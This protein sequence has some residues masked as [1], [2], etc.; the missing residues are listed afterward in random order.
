[1]NLSIVG[2]AAPLL[3]SF[4]SVADG[5]AATRMPDR[6]L[7]HNSLLASPARL[8]VRDVPLV[9]A[10]SALQERSGVPLAY[11]PT[12]LPADRHVSC[13]CLDATV[14]QAL[15]RLLNGTPFR[16]AEFAGQVLIER[17]RDEAR[18]AAEALPLVPGVEPVSLPLT[19]TVVN[20]KSGQPVEDARLEVVGEGNWT[21]SGAL[22]EFALHGLSPVPVMLK[23]SKPGY[24][25]VA[26][27]AFPGEELRIRIKPSLFSRPQTARIEGRVT[28]ADD[29]R[30]LALVRVLLEGTS[31]G[32]L[33]DADGRYRIEN[34]PPGT[35]T[36]AAR[37]LGFAAARR[38]NVHVA[39]DA[40]VAADF[41]L[42]SAAV[43]LDEQVVLGVTDATAGRNLPFSV[44]RLDAQDVASVPTTN[45]AV[46]ALQGKIAGV[47][48]VRGTGQ[49]GV[50]VNIQLRTPTSIRRS[51]SPMFV[52]DGVILGSN[53][54]GTT[55]DLES[56]DIES[57]EVV[58]GAAAASLYGSRAASGVVAI[59][60]SRGRNAPQGR[61]QV[62]TR[63]EFGQ[64]RVPTG[65]P[66][67][68]HH[69]Y[70]VNAQGQF[71]DAAGNPVTSFSQRVVEPDGMM[72]NA[73]G[74]PLYD[75]VGAF[76]QPGRFLTN[77]ISLSHNTTASNFMVSFN[78]YREAG[79]LENNDG[80][81][82]RN[83]RV[84]LDHHVG[85]IFSIG[86][87]AFH[88]RATRDDLTGSPFFDLLLYPP[89]VDL[90]VRDADGNYIPEP[91]STANLENPIW[92]Q[93]SR[94]NT[95][96][97]MRTLAN[98]T[99]RVAPFSWL[100]F[101]GVLSY[102]RSD[103]VDDDYVPRGTP[104]S[105]TSDNPSLGQIDKETE[106][107]DVLN[108][109]ASMTLTGHVDE[110][111]AR[112]TL[113]ALIERDEFRDVTIG[114][115]D[116]R[117]ANVPDLSVAATR[118]LNSTIEDIR[119]NGY[120]AQT[121]L[122]YRD[123]YIADLLVRRDGSSLFGPN[124][125]WQTYYRAGFAYR[126]AQERWWPIRWMD[127]FKLRY[128][129]GT[130]GGRPEFGD[131]YE[132]WQ[133]G[134]TGI[135]KGTL[136]NKDLKPEKT[137]EQEFGLDVVALGRY[138]LQLSYVRQLTRDQLIDVP[139]PAVTGYQTQW[140][141]AGTEGGRSWEATFEAEV[142]TGPAVRWSTTVVADRHRSWIAEW[143][144]ACFRDGAR[145]F[146]EGS[147][148]G[149]MWGEHFLR[150]PAELP[151]ANQGSRDQFQLN[152]D[153]WL[154]PVG[155]GASYRDGLWGTTV[156]IDGID[157]RWGIPIKALDGSGAPHIARMGRSDGDLNFG[158][159]NHVRWKAW[160]LDAHVQGQIGGNIY[161]ATRQ[162]MYQHLRHGDVDQAGKPDALKKPIDYY[163]AI[164][165][166]NNRVNAFVEDGSFVRLRELA[167]R[168]RVEGDAL[169]RI[170]VGRLGVTQLSVGLIG[171]N[172]LTMT[173]YR[174]FDPDVGEVLDRFDEFD[175]PLT[176]TVTAVLELVF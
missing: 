81:V 169:R 50:G 28:A 4:V 5:Q 133:V 19:G 22:G 63:T 77:S 135:S 104:L 155:P 168:Y 95:E 20:A 75:N 136:G 23:V 149:E 42:R 39:A 150:S 45:S 173:G 175:Y 142:L 31:F 139:L 110:L 11:S 123:R 119:S 3:L 98:I 79:A 170:G 38:G 111:T 109:S 144:R 131:Q 48:V 134:T 88:S 158:W 73:Y 157:Y 156:N 16:Y 47:Q 125:R 112:V 87:S 130:A 167:L 8:H 152:D 101:N 140:Q 137:T 59:R 67:T 161:N 36:I 103:V 2:V 91:D 164:Y 83:F 18:A 160:S 143:G 76:F 71:V 159:L 15:D 51:N 56:L 1:M 122:E 62:T 93:A 60:T 90:G 126:M 154:V 94:D 113:Q 33:T 46:A 78:D 100:T 153:G 108:A 166:S 72:D 138:A 105:V 35:Y 85:A 68:S 115:S 40:I 120:Y 171:R 116:L 84:N 97:R 102:D 127:E 30:P 107:S 43:T 17:S 89:D 74:V 61:T 128:S 132:T 21:V 53:I 82:R 151:A 69:H 117:V 25:G 57:I 37:L 26:T 121:A 6:I 54:D 145:L 162:R 41:T 32:A 24:G 176:R 7:A 80:F 147:S 141:N 124:E 49:P 92:R 163:L 129:R 27:H 86:A 9:A 13:R 14:G 55:V 148:L 118:T 29:D 70:R 58:K 65:V 99:A 44:G 146:C 174:G 96:T 10:L 66:I 106:T 52:V 172:L 34:V 165:N 114:G 64:S 12:L